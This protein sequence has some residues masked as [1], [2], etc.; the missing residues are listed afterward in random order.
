MER[1]Q[2]QTILPGIGISGQQK[3]QNSKVLV[4]GA[5]GLGCAVLP[6]LASAGV[7]SLDIVDG[8]KVELS[9]LHRQVLYSEKSIGEF[10]VFESEKALSSMNS[11]LTITTYPVFLTQENVEN[12]L[13]E[14]DLVIDATDNTE[15][16]YILDEA[17]RV[18][19][20]AMIY[21]S[22]FRFQGQVSVF[23]YQGGPSYRSLFPEEDQ[24]SLNCAEAGVLGTTVGMIGMLQANEALKIIL[25]I[26]EILSGKILIYNMLKNDQQIFELAI[27]EKVISEKA[28]SPTIDLISAEKALV[29]GGLLLDVR[30]L[31]EKP[32][33][34]LANCIQ[35]PL[36]VL[37]SRLD[38]ISKEAKITVFCQS[39]TRAISVA[40]IL[41]KANFQQV[42]AI[43]G[44]ASDVVKLIENEVK[45]VEIQD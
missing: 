45:S 22:I 36:S 3:L 1:F 16:R 24:S 31:G 25:G 9:N 33:V 40:K 34:D 30:E 20:K 11:E 13:S 26:G 43:R 29:E 21:G 39:G 4:V 44:G 17:C 14:N 5:G 23:N 2:R 38:E 10:K 32:V 18:A 28:I 42:K 27:Q 8:D 15:V 6:Y 37:E 12:L 41:K 7:G 35:I 19:G